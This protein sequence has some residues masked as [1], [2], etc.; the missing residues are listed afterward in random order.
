MK[1]SN[2][3]RQQRTTNDLNGCEFP[4]IIYSVI[5]LGERIEVTY[6]ELIKGKIFKSLKDM[7]KAVTT[8]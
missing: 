6:E 5:E 8:Y 2:M 1:Y 4:Y 7:K 3:T